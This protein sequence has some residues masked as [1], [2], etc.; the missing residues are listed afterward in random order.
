MA[1]R[2]SDLEDLQNAGIA[3]LEFACGLCPRRGNY[4][5]PG[6]IKRFGAS[7]TVME[8]KSQIAADCPR[9]HAASIYDLC[10][11]LYLNTESWAEI[12]KH[13][14]SRNPAKQRP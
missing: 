5:L 14:P 10:Q 12:S 2:I 13:P 9:Q 7:T 1:C 6:L 4:G 3:R 11:V 8:L